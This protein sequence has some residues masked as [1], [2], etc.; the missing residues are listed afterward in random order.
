MLVPASCNA[1]SKASIH[2]VAV[3]AVMREP[4]VGRGHDVDSSLSYV[5]S[6]PTA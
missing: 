4:N 6:L 2:G 3:L 1:G 5:I